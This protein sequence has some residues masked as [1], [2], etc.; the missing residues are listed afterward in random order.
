MFKLYLNPNEL[1]R[2]I[3][4]VEWDN[5]ERWRATM[6]EAVND[7]IKDQLVNTAAFGASHPEILEEGKSL[8][9]IEFEM[10]ALRHDLHEAAKVADAALKALPDFE[11]IE[12]ELA[13]IEKI[14]RIGEQIADKIFSMKPKT[15]DG[16]EAKVRA[17]LWKAGNYMDTYLKAGSQ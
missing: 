12:E 15:P 10:L 16:I 9:P 1:P 14:L 7:S 6:E 13:A 11:T 2:S 3:S 5:L 8:C 17:G 4:G